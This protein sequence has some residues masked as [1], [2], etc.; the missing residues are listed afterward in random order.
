VILTGARSTAQLFQSW[1]PNIRLFA[2]TSG[3]NSLIITGMAD[4][5]QAIKDLVRSAFGHSGQKC[6]AASLAI[7]EAE[8]YD[9]PTF[10]RQLKD[11][12]A[13]LHV[14][15]AWDATSKVTPIIRPAGPEL[16]Q[17]LTK[18]EPGEEWLLEP[19]MIDSNS[20][21]WS[22]GIKLGVQPGS[23]FHKTECF[24]PVLGLMRADNLKHAVQLANE[25]DFGLTGGIHS[26][27]QREIDY[28]QANIEVGNAYINRH[29]TGAIVQ[30]QPF[31]GWK[32]SVVG[33]GAKAGG[34]NYLFQLAQWQQ[35]E[36]PKHQARTT[37]SVAKFQAACL[38]VV[39]DTTKKEILKASAG[40]YAWAWQTH[41]SKTE[42]PSQLRGEA[43]WFRYRPCNGILLRAEANADIVALC[44]VVLAT[45]T[46]G[47]KL[48]VSLS[49]SA[50]RWS[51]LGQADD[52]LV[53]FEN[54]NSL[55]SRLRNSAE[56]DRLRVV[57]LVSTRLYEAANEADV[58]IIDSPVLVNGRLELRYY[59]RE[60]AI[61]HVYHRYGNLIP[62]PAR[63]FM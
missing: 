3:K 40:S 41:F 34:P 47:V 38:K 21:L 12:A 17:A 31:G 20:C 8:V 61:S 23:F 26:L 5:D 1:K 30:R 56:Y 22:P 15:S 58:A 14:G 9:N 7:C 29:I 16:E 39:T 13:S 25:V 35:R 60:Q 18:L 57:G 2:E 11:A 53:M 6:S 28:W 19:K 37:D 45:M 44:Q 49:P 4:H 48:T 50:T 42:D 55:I 43:N 27:D 52:V 62:P 54:E 24:G 32:G 10:R 51:W 33:P 63:D 46:C 36:L 59:L